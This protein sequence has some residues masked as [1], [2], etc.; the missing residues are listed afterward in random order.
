M[1]EDDIVKGISAPGRFD[2]TVG[3][4]TDALRIVQTAIPHAMELSPAATGQPYPS[5]PQGVK[6][7]FQVQ[8]AEPSV[9]NNQPHVKYADWTGGKKGR[10][11]SWGHIFFPPPAGS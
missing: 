5:P 4:E 3:S 9:G 6:A 2:A 11:G 8:P 7:W 1:T 10:G